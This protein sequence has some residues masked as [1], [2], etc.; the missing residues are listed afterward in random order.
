MKELVKLP[1]E[2]LN[3]FLS[4]EL[5]SRRESQR[6]LHMEPRRFQRPFKLRSRSHI[7]QDI[8]YTFSYFKKSARKE[9]RHELAPTVQIIIPLR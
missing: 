6:M 4:L 3:L 5:W 2:F 7:I 8:G 1:Q 9:S